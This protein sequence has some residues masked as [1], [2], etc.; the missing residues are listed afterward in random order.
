MLA[1]GGRGSRLAVEA[2]VASAGIGNDTVGQSLPALVFSIGVTGHRSLADDPELADAVAGTI[3]RVLDSISAA[4]ERLPPQSEDGRRTTLRIVTMLAEGADIIGASEAMRRSVPVAV[5]LPGSIRAYRSTFERQQWLDR[6]DAT[7]AD[8]HSVTELPYEVIDAADYERANGFIL[9]QSD[10]L[11]A[12][13]DGKPARGRGGTGSVVQDALDR[14]IP[15]VVIDPVLAGEASVIVDPAA[16]MLPGRV[17]DLP[18]VPVQT[19]LTRLVA[20]VLRPPWA[21]SRH[22]AL[23][24]YLAEPQKLRSWRVAQRLLKLVGYSFRTARKRVRKGPHEP[25][26]PDDPAAQRIEREFQRADRLA[27]HYGDQ[28]RSTMVSRYFVIAFAAFVNAAVSI[29][30]PAYLP[31]STLIQLIVTVSSLIDERTARRR[32]W[33]E[34]WLD[35]RALAEG[36]RCL[37][38]VHPLG[39]DDEV[40]RRSSP[41]RPLHWT[42]WYLARLARDIGP[43]PGALTPEEIGRR[44]RGIRDLIG[45]QVEY[46]RKALRDLAR[47]DGRLRRLSTISLAATVLAGVGSLVIQFVYPTASSLLPSIAA[48]LL[49]IAPAFAVA[50]SGL[51]SSADL[52][53]LAQRS[54]RTAA[55]LS[56]IGRQMDGL[57]PT[58]DRLAVAA[59][60]TCGAMLQELLEWRFI[61]ESRQTGRLRTLRGRR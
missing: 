20:S 33:H 43:S 42:E 41:A 12:V 4:A 30:L 37:R 44:Y 9:A 18:R 21:P 1:P 57:P 8:A 46:H 14:K 51:R 25:A 6:F 55:A 28:M 2:D 34:R 45:E 52:A 29:L 39:M 56:R 16:A 7:I 61:R 10:L 24:D 31:W 23:K 58:F 36:L 38:H 48:A 11:L 5:I 54:A 17:Y 50:A 47:L 13:W 26:L 19:A 35:Y 53:R 3:G 15:V 60:M 49:V 32:R 40:Y 59:R 27:N 22:T